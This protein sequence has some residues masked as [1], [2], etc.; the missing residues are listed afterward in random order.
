LVFTIYAVD[1]RKKK[2]VVG[3]ATWPLDHT[4]FTHKSHTLDFGDNE[5][6]E[7]PD[8]WRKTGEI[9]SGIKGVKQNVS[10]P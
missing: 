1:V 2:T 9:S 3:A 7:T 6:L 8:I 4:S 5:E 10:R